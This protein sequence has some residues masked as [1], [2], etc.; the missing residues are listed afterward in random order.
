MPLHLK[1][2]KGINHCRLM[3]INGS[4]GLTGL[5]FLETTLKSSDKMRKPLLKMSFGPMTISGRNIFISC[6]IIQVRVS[7]NR[8][9]T[10][11]PNGKTFVK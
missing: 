1:Q 8:F 11:G 10:I 4:L 6:S 9:E 5:L 7:E 2:A 3:S